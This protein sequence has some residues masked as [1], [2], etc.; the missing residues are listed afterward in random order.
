MTDAELAVVLAATRLSASNYATLV[1]AP[2]DDV[3][4]SADVGK[5]RFRF[6]AELMRASSF[7]R[8]FKCSAK[9]LVILARLL[10]DM[11]VD[12]FSSPSTVLLIA[13]AV[14]SV[15]KAGVSLPELAW[16]LRHD[17]ADDFATDEK[18]VARAFAEFVRGIRTI[19][20]ETAE[21]SDPDG[22]AT[23]LHLATVITDEEDLDEAMAI[24]ANASQLNEED[25]GTFIDTH[26]ASFT[27]TAAAKLALVTD[28]GTLG[29]E[30]DDAPA[31]YAWVLG[32]FIGSLR[33]KTLLE[34][35]AARELKIEAPA[36]GAL[37]FDVLTDPQD[38]TRPLAEVFL[39]DFASETEIADGI[40]SATHPDQ[41]NAWL[42]LRKAATIVRALKINAGQIAW[43][44]NHAGWVDL[45]GLPLNPIDDPV[46]L[47]SW[48]HLLLAM[49]VRKLFATPDG[50]QRLEDAADVA[51]AIAVLVEANDWDAG[52]LETLLGTGYLNWP[53]P[54]T[55]ANPEKLIQL[56]DLSRLVARTG[57]PLLRLWSWIH[58][59]KTAF[60]VATEVKAAARARHDEASWLT[61]APKLRDKIRAAQR[62]A[63]VAANLAADSSLANQDALSQHLLI[64]VAMNPCMKTSRVVQAIAAVQLFIHRV[65]LRL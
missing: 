36:A 27:D 49:E 45:D 9:E 50:H 8:A 20:D 4:T 16:L 65:F 43:Y 28:G 55:L 58:G 14:D 63:L 48:Y 42:R 13:R 51:G 37:L 57:V 62:D 22:E 61:I 56:R 39:V 29:G 32:Q 15:R 25:Q 38:D 47:M 40:T 6:F 35:L 18:A 11:S 60:E 24:L 54:A 59:S 33:R 5:F 10:A 17:F 31:R 30:P 44:S 12:P 3:F 21:L 2:G 41:F 53:T 1:T 26:F 23:R 34:D 19:A 7:M 52:E 64:D 46:I